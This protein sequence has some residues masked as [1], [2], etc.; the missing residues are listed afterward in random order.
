MNEIEFIGKLK[1]AA[2]REE[3]PPVDVTRAVTAKLMTTKGEGPWG[4]LVWVAICASAV[5]LPVSVLALYAL[6]GWTDPILNVFFAFRW[7]ML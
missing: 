5:A 4:P 7:V 3:I 2:R 6:D 1:I